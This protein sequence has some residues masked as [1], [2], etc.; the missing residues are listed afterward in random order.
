MSCSLIIVAYHSDSWLPA[1][2]ET[3]S[4]V[5]P[6]QTHLVLVDNTG[7]SCIGDIDLSSF[8]AE[9]LNCEAPLGF[10]AA[11]NFALVKSRKLRE[12]VA[13]VNQDTRSNEDWLTPCLECLRELPG[14]AAVTPLTMNYDSA[15]WDPY[16]L[17]CARK[18]P[19]FASEVDGHGRFDPFYEVPVIPAAAMLVRTETLRIVGPFDPIYDSYYEDYDLC[20]RLIR[21]GYRAGVC[22]AGRICHHGGSATTSVA[23]ERR[24]ARWVTRNRV[25][26][27]QREFEGSRLLAFLQH[28]AFVFPRDLA[29]SLLRRPGAKPPGPYLAAHWDLLKLAPRLVSARRDAAAWQT[30]LHDI[31]W[32]PGCDNR[33]QGAETS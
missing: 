12:F 21:A 6:T 8:D 10:A 14:V 16:F 7:N 28:W 25:I 13:F 32:P 15:D 11:N 1:C 3:L 19:G 26:V 23:A 18:S 33:G 20:Y 9:I 31:G 30:Y 29:R 17:E 2:I 5:V 27:R 24:R 22:T 4:E